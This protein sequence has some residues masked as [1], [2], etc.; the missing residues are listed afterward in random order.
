M[1]EEQNPEQLKVIYQKLT[2]SQ[3]EAY[4]Q[5]YFDAFPGSFTLFVATFGDL[6][7]DH[8]NFNPAP[9]YEESHSYVRA[10]FKLR[11]IDTSTYL[12]KIIDI[13]I[14]GSWDAD[15]VSYLQHE[16]RT[17][18]SQSV[19]SFS[20]H[21]SNRT[22]EEVKSFWRFY[23]DEPYPP[24]KLPEELEQIKKLNEQVYLLMVSALSEVQKE[25]K[26]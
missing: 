22:Q 2:S 15:A 23:F 4:D 19:E 14:G 21:L 13:C 9:L 17:V 12:N 20:Q 16:V 26:D 25:W 18:T 11:S 5:E 24:E 1:I 6:A 3:G 8:E 10:F 7:D